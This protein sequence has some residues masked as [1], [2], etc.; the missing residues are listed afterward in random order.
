[1]S[2]DNLLNQ[3]LSDVDRLR[4]LR[5]LQVH[6]FDGDTLY[7]RMAALA[8]RVTKSP[9]SL[10]TMVANNYQ[11]FK[12]Y[13]GLPEPWRTS[14]STPLSHSFC[15]HLLGSN[16][17]LVVYDARQVDFLKE[18]RAIPDIKV[19]AYLGVPLT[20]QSEQLSLGSFCIID[21]AP[22]RWTALEI[23]IMQ[24]LAHIITT[25]LD[26]RA[27][28][29]RQASLR[30]A[31]NGLQAEINTFIEQTPDEIDGEAFLERAQNFLTTITTL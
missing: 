9:V 3:T 18:N 30:A 23:E 19:I 4:M 12:G 22:R 13:T 1:M 20:I 16:E 14:R 8:A 7:D 5:N 31:L 26:M 21:H 27:R 15:Q 25:E 6:I 2:K 28:V 10:V 24:T 29:V 17:P 11:F